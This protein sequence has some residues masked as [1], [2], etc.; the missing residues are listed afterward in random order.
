LLSDYSHIQRENIDKATVNFEYLSSD[1]VDT[2]V[3]FL[4]GH[5]IIILRSVNKWLSQRYSCHTYECNKIYLNEFMSDVTLELLKYYIDRIGSYQLC[6]KIAK[7]AARYDK[8]DI[9]EWLKDVNQEWVSNIHAIQGGPKTKQWLANLEH[10]V[11]LCIFD[12]TVAC[13]GPKVI[14]FKGLV[15]YENLEPVVEKLV[16]RFYENNPN[17]I[18]DRTGYFD[19]EYFEEFKL[20]IGKTVNNLLSKRYFSCNGYNKYYSV[21]FVLDHADTM[22]WSKDV[23]STR[24][25]DLIDRNTNIDT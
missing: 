2:I 22:I 7:L 21:V 9:L 4:N 3:G 13:H 10:T 5:H 20:N 12:E 19:D 24:L 25:Y 6:T 18:N 11:T 14:K 17:H 23:S 8:V 1:V 16:R 15:K